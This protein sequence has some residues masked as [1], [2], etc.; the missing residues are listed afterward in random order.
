MTKIHIVA[1]LIFGVF[2]GD[3]LAAEPGEASVP[4]DSVITAPDSSVP[5]E[6]AVFSG[7]WKGAWGSSLSG[8]LAV[9][10]ITG[11]GSVSGIYAVGD[12]PKGKF[13]AQHT[14]CTGQIS[15]GLLTL[16]PFPNGAV[17]SYELLDQNTLKGTFTRKG[18]DTSG[19]FLREQ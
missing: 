6:Y 4:E 9:L 18:T 19:I 14:I 13:K 3:C 15:D 2:L 10:V 17:A 1:V 12:D 7:I 16:S 8:K 5:S 11:D